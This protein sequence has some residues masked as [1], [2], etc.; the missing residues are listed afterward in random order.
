MLATSAYWQVNR[1]EAMKSNPEVNSK[2]NS[3]SE[4]TKHS[5]LKTKRYSEMGKKKSTIMHLLK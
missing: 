4:T 2:M 5:F 3:H 1:L